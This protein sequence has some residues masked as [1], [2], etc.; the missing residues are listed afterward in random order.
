MR[1]KMLLSTLP[2]VWLI[3]LDG[4][5]V[6]HNGYLADGDILLD[7]VKE[8]FKNNINVDDFIIILTSR[9]KKYK[10]QT[11]EFLKSEGIPFDLVIYDLPYGERI[12]INDSKPSG[13]LTAYAINKERDDPLY[14]NVIRCQD[15]DQP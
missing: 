15:N 1:V 14:L 3:D 4:T 6:K 12:L 11:E 2:K 8:F 13:L 9:P 10:N 5:L 7:G